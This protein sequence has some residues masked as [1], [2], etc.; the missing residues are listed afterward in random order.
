MSSANT[1]ATRLATRLAFLVAGFGIASWAPLIPFAKVR[2][3][4]DDGTLGLLLLCL[5]AGSVSS[6]VLTGGLC[7][8]YGSKPV[9]G[10][11]GVALALLVPVL[12]LAPTPISLAIALFCFG[13]ALGTLDV[14]M[15]VHAVAVEQASTLPLMSGFHGMFSVGGFAGAAVM[16]G[17]LSL[18]VPPFAATA[19]CATAMLA[20]MA[21][22]WPRLLAAKPGERGPMFVKPH[23]LIFVLA[24]LAAITFLVEGALLDWS[25]LLVTNAGL[26]AVAQGGLGYMLFAIAMTVGRFGGDAVVAKIG[27]QATLFWGGLASVTG[28]VILLFAPVFGVAVAGFLLIGLGA[29]NLVPVL[30]RRSGS[31]RVMPAALAVSAITTV[32]YAGVLVGPALIGFVAQAVGLQSAFWMLA[33]LLCAVPASARL[34]A[35]V[36]T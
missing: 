24:G 29:S 18:H 11:A 33:L 1:P 12:V 36:R 2:L 7:S 22:V 26:V 28:F 17:L 3:A 21:V 6:M 4:V 15:N 14:A 30:F 20:A 27:D 13:A 16:T 34:V 32:G 19:L 35:P 31:Q 8:R 23:G 5:G 10:A 9:V 25:A